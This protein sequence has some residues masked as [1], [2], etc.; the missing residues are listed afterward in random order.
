MEDIVNSLD[1]T[2]LQL[3]PAIAALAESGIIAHGDPGDR[4]IAADRYDTSGTSYL[5]RMENSAPRPVY[6]AFG[7]NDLSN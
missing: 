7:N 5:L 6:G 2:I 1:L 3:T 4:L